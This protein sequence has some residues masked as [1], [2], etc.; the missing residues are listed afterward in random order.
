M[1]FIIVLIKIF[2]IHN[3]RK[4]FK[5]KPGLFKARKFVGFKTDFLLISFHVDDVEFILSYFHILNCM[6]LDANKGST[7]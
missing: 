1:C 7:L 2:K 6:W 5:F 4:M 3:F